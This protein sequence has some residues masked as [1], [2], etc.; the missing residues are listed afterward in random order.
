MPSTLYLLALALA[1]LTVTTSAQCVTPGYVP[2]LPQGSTLGGVAP[3]DFGNSGLWDTLQGVA[4]DPIQKKG[5][6]NAILQNPT[7]RRALAHRLVAR[8]NA[9]CCAPDPDKYCLLLTDKNIPFCYVRF[10][11]SFLLSTVFLFFEHRIPSLTSPSFRHRIANNFSPL[12]QDSTT[13][14]FVFSDESYGYIDNGTYY[15]ADGTFVDFEDGTYSMTDGETGSFAPA[16]S[17]A[18]VQASGMPSATVPGTGK[19]T[20]VAGSGGSSATSPSAVPGS[21]AGSGPSSSASSGT[22]AK[23]S[24]GAVG[25]VA[26]GYA[27]SALAA[28][29]VAFAI[30]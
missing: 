30:L 7:K 19:V 2:C 27:L 5:K 12:A 20:G 8:Q 3:A 6:R 28:G 14:R 15:A 17:A 25:S 4:S 22:T 23:K 11:P 29:V 9:L 24:E 26:G 13:T 21:S 10:V 18:A 16:T 1:L